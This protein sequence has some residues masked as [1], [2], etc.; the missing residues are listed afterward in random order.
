MM[1]EQGKGKEH[2]EPTFLALVFRYAICIKRRSTSFYYTTAK[3]YNLQKATT[4]PASPSS[5]PQSALRLLLLPFF[6]HQPSQQHFIRFS[7]SP[8]FSAWS[9]KISCAG[10]HRKAFHIEDVKRKVLDLREK[11]ISV[12]PSIHAFHRV[13]KWYIHVAQ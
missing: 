5:T 6:V 4:I 10:S 3:L 13:S 12:K 11:R 9:Y 2:F 7:R 1:M 8:F